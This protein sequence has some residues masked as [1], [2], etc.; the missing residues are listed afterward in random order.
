MP[1]V[2]VVG[3][4]NTL[5]GD[6]GVGPAVAHVVAAWNRPDV[7]ALAVYQLTPELAEHVARAQLAIFVD[8]SVE[9]VAGEGPRLRRVTADARVPVMGHTGD[10]SWLLALAEAVFGRVAESWLIS[11]PVACLALGDGLSSTGVAGKEWALQQIREMLADS[12][13]LRSPQLLLRRLRHDDTAAVVAYRS[14]PEV[15]RFQSWTTFGHEDAIRLIENQAAVVP[16]TPGTWLQLGIV[17]ADVG[18]VVGDVG[19][20]FR[21]D[22]PEQVELGITLSPAYQGR[23]LAAEALRLVLGYVFGALGKHRVIAVTDA[24]NQAA[25]RLFGRL[26][27]RREGHFVEH[28]WY[29]GAWGSEYLFA[30]LHREWGADGVGS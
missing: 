29:K 21:A 22:E 14:L 9:V 1:G 16:N 7:Q 4:G 11:L 6:D 19:I 13:E 5:R 2:L 10:P 3:Y 12:P 15:A 18:T 26:G 27:F 30:L 20:H 17:P 24:E 25:A 28:V 8:A 23:G